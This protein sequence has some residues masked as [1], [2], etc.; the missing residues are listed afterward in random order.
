MGS[1]VLFDINEFDTSAL[2]AIVEE[3]AAIYY[4]GD[5][6]VFVGT[7]TNQ[8]PSVQDRAKIDVSDSDMAEPREQVL[9]TRTQKDLKFSSSDCF[10]VFLMTGFAYKGIKWSNSSSF[11]RLMNHSITEGQPSYRM[12]RGEMGCW[13]LFLSASEDP[14]IGFLSEDMLVYDRFNFKTLGDSGWKISF[15]DNR[16][17]TFILENDEHDTVLRVPCEFDPSCASSPF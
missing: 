5:S 17:G 11:T 14:S 12:F 7:D 6:R 16:S 8:P 9:M 10:I 1:W 15:T 3:Q 4:G 13:W 2:M